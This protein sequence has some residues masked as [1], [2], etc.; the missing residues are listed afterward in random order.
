MWFVIYTK[1]QNDILQV[2]NCITLLL[3]TLQQPIL[4]RTDRTIIS[5]LMPATS[6]TLHSLS[7]AIWVSLWCLVLVPCAA[8]S[9]EVLWYHHLMWPSPTTLPPTLPCPRSSS[10]SNN[11]S[12]S[13]SS[14]SNNNK[15]V[16]Q[17]PP[18]CSQHS[19]PLSATHPPWRQ[20]DILCDWHTDIQAS[21]SECY[22]TGSVWCT[23]WSLLSF[24]LNPWDL[25]PE[26]WT[27]I[28]KAT[29][30]WVMILI[31]LNKYLP[32]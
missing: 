11:N 12:S 6:H 2:P 29:V 32:W 23:S 10:S 24:A 9:I 20:R 31:S 30:D 4:L 14:S 5:H 7:T 1:Q 27:W 3:A 17:H 26:H 21:L 16:P 18:H 15:T 8:H 13:S 25:L 28:I 19:T 22:G